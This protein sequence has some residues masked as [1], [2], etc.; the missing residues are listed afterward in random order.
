[1]YLTASSFRKDISSSKESLVAVAITLETAS[2]ISC[3]CGTEVVGFPVVPNEHRVCNMQSAP[4][5]SE[6]GVI[7]VGSRKL[8]VTAAL[9]R[10]LRVAK[11]RAEASPGAG[12][13][14]SVIL[15]ML[16]QGLGDIWIYVRATSALSDV[17]T[18]PVFIS[19]VWNDPEA[20]SSEV[21][22]SEHTPAF[23]SAPFPLGCF[24]RRKSLLL[25]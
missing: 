8:D 7:E 12:S 22:T 6:A 20:I 4:S 24:L 11:S 5:P 25:A 2:L 17:L 13:C 10:V 16:V 15:Q 18:P 9:D 21:P 19:R 14:E 3:P 1:M 23:V